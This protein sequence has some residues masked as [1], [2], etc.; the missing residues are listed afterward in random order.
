[1]NVNYKRSLITC[2]IFGILFFY[3][4]IHFA[5]VGPLGFQTDRIHR[6][7]SAAAIL[8]AMVGFAIMLLLTNKKE[9]VF[10]ER[11]QLIQ[12]QAS[13]IGL[14][15]TSMFVFIFSIILFVNYQDRG[16]LEVSWVWLIAYL[17]FSFAYFITSLITVYLYKVDE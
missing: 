16:V 1:M 7:V 15:L 11:D 4:V 6:V 2:I 13:T 17:T 9:K 14:M 8:V 12:K 5:I 3:L 10:D